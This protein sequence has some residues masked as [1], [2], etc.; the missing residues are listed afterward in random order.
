MGLNV[1]EIQ[2]IS[3][4]YLILCHCVMKVT[5]TWEV[6]ENT[7][8]GVYRITHQGFYKNLVKVRPSN[9]VTIVQYLQ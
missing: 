1:Y 2:C 5:V 8:N 4:L 6:P 3:V 7:P 9:T